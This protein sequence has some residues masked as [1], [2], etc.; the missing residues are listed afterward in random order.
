ML[1]S[2]FLFS[3]LVATGI[4]QDAGTLDVSFNKTGIRVFEL[5]SGVGAA[6]L[7]IEAQ[8]DGKLV[9]AGVH[10]I[11]Q[12][13]E[14]YVVRMHQDGR[15]DSSFHFDG[16]VTI[17]MSNEDADQASCLA[18]RPNGKILVAGATKKGGDIDVQVFQLLDDGA[19][20]PN[21]GALGV[22]Q[23]DINPQTN[24]ISQKVYLLSDGSSL[25][26]GHSTGNGIEFA[27]LMKLTEQ[28]LLDNTFGTNGIYLLDETNPVTIKDLVVLQGNKLVLGVD[29]S[30][31]S[32]STIGLVGL[33]ANGTLD[34]SFGNGGIAL[35]ALTSA[36]PDLIIGLKLTPDKS[37]LM[38]IGM[39]QDASI[40]ILLARFTISGG[41]DL[42]FGNGGFLAVDLSNGDNDVV[43]DALVQ[44]DG[45]VL[46]QGKIGGETYI[47]RFLED[48]ALDQGFNQTGYWRYDLNPGS[49]DEPAAISLDRMGRIIS[50][51]YF[52]KAGQFLSFA[53]AHHVNDVATGI[54]TPVPVALRAYPNPSS[55]IFQVELPPFTGNAL[56]RVVDMKG[57]LVEETTIHGLGSGL[58]LTLD[59]QPWARGI[60]AI[61]LD[62]EGAR[63]QTKFIRP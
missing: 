53:L 43:V 55:G 40:D 28:G 33:T 49:Q 15:F 38:A 48:G 29:F 62:Q 27:W 25:V 8:L 42:S 47:A 1:I 18:I 2:T 17:D 44:G 14:A 26:I 13:V 23:F 58:V 7:D 30:S 37:K 11:G 46:T 10:N 21:F 12:D 32:S 34:P 19:L 61:V 3:L 35:H 41:I 4:A 59:A 50:S 9:L 45:K 56:C 24:D 39:T 36:Q 16:K 20:D 22:S 63:W 5:E 52:K 6:C 31:V 60:Y 57:R 54:D 51:G